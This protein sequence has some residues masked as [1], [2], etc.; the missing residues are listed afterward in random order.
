ML[1]LRDHRS[2]NAGF[3]LVELMVAMSIGLVLLGVVSTLF[4]ASKG[5]F[6][7]ADQR[8]RVNEGLRAV[9]EAVGTYGRQAGYYDM[10][11][12]TANAP[13]P[14]T[15]EDLAKPDSTGIVP[16]FA[17]ADGRVDFTTVPW[18]CTANTAAAG[19]LPSDSIVF[20]YQ[21][22]P[23]NAL[24]ANSTLLAFSN[25]FGGDCNGQNPMPSPAIAGNAMP[26]NVPFAINEFYVGRGVVTTQGGSSVN[27]PELYCRGNGNPG[28]AQ[29]MAQGVEQIRARFAFIDSNP[30]GFLQ[31]TRMTDIA[32]VGGNWGSV[33]TVYLCVLTQSP[34]NV[35]SSG[36]A[37][38]Y[39]DCDNTTRT[40]TDNRLRKA[41]RLTITLRNRINT[42]TALH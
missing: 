12:T 14:V 1:S 41:N 28:A 19:I 40:A 20:S 30:G 23:S 39:T 4:L 9:A 27:I 13:S 11:N 7:S 38:T 42:F 22:Q 21:T 36:V 17:C 35:Y 16:V 2:S 37:N 26:V 34:S 25:G 32:G 3:S 15:F 5:S 10:A 8:G 29:P 18:S 6:V 24:I 33:Y 31:Q